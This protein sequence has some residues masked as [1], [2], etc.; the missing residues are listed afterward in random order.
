M[1]VLERVEADSERLILAA[2]E[3]KTIDLLLSLILRARIRASKDGVKS[4]HLRSA[5]YRLKTGRN[6]DAFITLDSEH[7]RIR[8]TDDGD[9]TPYSALAPSKRMLQ[10]LA[11]KIQPPKS[12]ASEQPS[13]VESA[14]ARSKADKSELG[15]DIEADDEHLLDGD[16]FGI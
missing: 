3:R 1:Y 4:E 7:F 16:R 10:R 5:L 11:S 15:W 6:V 2:P 8:E 9:E 14:V 13:S 12:P